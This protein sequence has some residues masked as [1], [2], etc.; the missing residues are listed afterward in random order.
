L[1]SV[2]VNDMEAERGYR[3]ALRAGWQPRP[4]RESVVNRS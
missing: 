2:S 1:D 4:R 3:R